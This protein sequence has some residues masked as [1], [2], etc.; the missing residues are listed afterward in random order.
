MLPERAALEPALSADLVMPLGTGIFGP[1]KRL[2]LFAD[3][4]E[5]PR[6]ALLE[7]REP[8]EFP[9]KFSRAFALAPKPLPPL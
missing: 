3:E 6:D 8:C 5:F 7:L 1:P 9:L 4:L 2:S